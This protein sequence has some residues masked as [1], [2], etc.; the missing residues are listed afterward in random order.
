[1]Q[2]LIILA[3]LTTAII[4]N[5]PKRTD[6]ANNVA[7]LETLLHKQ[8]ATIES[9]EARL[10]AQDT[11]LLQQ[12]ATLQTVLREQQSMDARIAKQ[13][14]VVGFYTDFGYKPY[15]DVTMKTFETLKFPRVL[16]NSGNGY[17]STTGIFTT[18]FSGLYT[19]QLQFSGGT[20]NDT[21]QLSISANSL[22]VAVAYSEGDTRDQGSQG[23]CSAV[24]H[25][26]KGNQVSVRF[27]SGNPMIW[28][29]RLASFS[30]VL[31]HSD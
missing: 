22:T 25:L 20:H 9:L 4:A 29:S 13:E 26:V 23:S 30:G 6:D 21:T 18:P 7:A 3:F 12:Q 11:K 14:Q 1:M 5:K 10:T 15:H 28:A 16:T 19:F 24:V 27:L 17:N 31:V 2:Y 8:A